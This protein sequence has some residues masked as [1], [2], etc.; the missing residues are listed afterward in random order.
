MLF[1]YN[2]VNGTLVPPPLDLS[3]AN[4]DRNSVEPISPRFSG[5]SL[6]SEGINCSKE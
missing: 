5:R 1:S 3:F 2:E 6:K 4:R